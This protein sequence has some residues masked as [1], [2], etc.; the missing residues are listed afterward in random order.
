MLKKSSLL[1]VLTAIICV[2]VF[3]QE[4]TRESLFDDNWK[5]YRGK[6]EGAEN[7]GFDDTKWRTLNLPHDWSIDDLP[8]QGKFKL[9]NGKTQI[10]SGPFDSEAIGAYNT[11]YTVGGTGWYR[12][13]FTLPKNLEG[14]VISILFDG[15]YMNADVWINGHHLG[16]HPYGYTAFGFELSGFLNFGDKENI[17]AVEV[18]NEGVNSRWYSGS[19]I[20]RHVF[21]ETTEKIHVARWG[22]FINTENA[23]SLTAVVDIKTTVNNYDTENA[24]VEL[25]CSIF[26]SQLQKVAEQKLSTQLYRQLP[27]TLNL[28]LNVASPQLWSPDSPSLYKAE[29]SIVKDGKVIDKT[30]T[31]FGIRTFRFDSEK[32]F[33]LN[34]KPLKMK[35]GAMHANNGPLGAVANDRAEERRVE[36]MK[37]AGFNA[38]RC[39]HNPPSS[40]FLNACDR[41]GMLVIDEAFDVWIKGWRDQDY[42]IYFND[43]WKKDIASM[44]MR[45]RNHPGIFTWSICNQV[46]ENLDST[47]IALANQIVDFIHTLDPTRP[48]SANV[49]QT[50][51]NWKISLPSVILT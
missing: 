3:S 13:Y 2:P 16:N 19:G 8:N 24:D 39:A 17:I 37:A 20:Y 15:V 18:K 51:R 7:A 11:G 45:D 47:G 25:V 38:I 1:F 36:L 44:V 4:F 28:K 29:C 12:K 21:L 27:S 41:L 49:A 50:G 14:K 32:G 30:V 5:F 48:V 42:H 33:I 23:D 35:G 46:R 22:T 26:N 40:V 9:S 6:A 31:T 34:G 10:V 43:W